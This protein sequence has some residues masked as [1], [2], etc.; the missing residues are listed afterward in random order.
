M[1]RFLLVR[2]CDLSGVSGTGIVAEGVQFSDGTAVMH[3]LREP[4]GLN[5]YTRIEDLLAVHGHSGASCI[6]WLDGGND[7]ILVHQ[8]EMRR[9]EICQER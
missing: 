2:K 4:F 8:P 1:R 3:W 7:G 9:K 6:E 5:I